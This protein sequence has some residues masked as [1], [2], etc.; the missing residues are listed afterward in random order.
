MWSHDKESFDIVKSAWT[1]ID[2][3]SSTK[4]QATLHCLS[5]WGQSHFGDLPNKINIIQTQLGLLKDQT[6]TIDIL[7]QIKCVEKDL[8]NI[9]MQE[10]VW[11]AQRAK[12]QWLKYGDNNTKFFHFK[13][14][15]RRKKNTIYAIQDNLGVPWNDDIHIHNTFIN[16]FAN[17]FSTSNPVNVPE[18][19]DVIRNRVPDHMKRELGAEFSAEEVIT[20]MKSMKSISSPGPDGMPAL[21]FKNTGTLLARMFFSLLSISLTMR[22]I[23]VVS[24]TLILLLFPKL[25]TL[26]FPLTIGPSVCVMSSLKLLLKP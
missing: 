25:R 2:G 11:W 6:P 18:A 5:R 4:I 23:L 8:S 13:V 26:P 16:H 1:N 20:A 17:I 19:F 24:I 14:N 22:V 9:L 21:F 12:M 15:Q 7:S 3:D 10:E